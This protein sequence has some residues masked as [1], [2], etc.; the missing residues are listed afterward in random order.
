[1][2]QG[3]VLSLGG[4]NM[5]FQARVERMPEGVETLSGCDFLMAGGGKA[6]NVACMARRLGARSQLLAHVGDD[7][8][9]RQ[10]LEPLRDVGI[11]LSHVRAI[12]G[13]VTAVSM[14]L[15]RPGGRKTSV[16]ANNANEVWS[17]DDV[18][19]ALAA[20]RTAPEG[21]VLVADLEVP[22]RVVSAVVEAARA[23]DFRVV[24]APSRAERMPEDLFRCVD[25]LTLDHTEAQELCG[26]DIDS[27]EDAADAGRR[28]RGRG[29][30]SVCIKLGDGG[31]VAV[32]GQE[33]VR[34]PPFPVPEVVD[35]AGAGD[36]FTGALAIALLEGQQVRDA[37]RF[38]TAASSLAITRNGARQ[39]W[40]GRAELERLLARRPGRQEEG[41]TS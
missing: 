11:E 16:L 40:P 26:M 9:G 31:C 10:A 2:K 1:M 12:S 33:V 8:L 13:E 41:T 39:A 14:I 28:L 15:V 25:F 34:I 23:R 38:A 19:D 30:G 7:A 5:E 36:A 22:T 21:S 3:W 18:V 4:V 27:E 29:V 20:V 35:R 6:A 37:V 32:T 17:Q 24:L